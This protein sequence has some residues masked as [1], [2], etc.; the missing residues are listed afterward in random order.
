LASRSNPKASGPVSIEV[1]IARQ[2]MYIRK[3]GQLYRTIRVSTGS[4]KRYCTK[5]ECGVA[6]TPRGRFRIGHRISGW[7]TSRLGRLFSPLY[8]SGGFAIHGS[9]SVPGYPASH[10][11]VR[12]TMG[13]ARWLPSQVPNGTPVWIH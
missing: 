4:G 3:G 1:S 12:I 13:D 8:F 11:C 7:R 5:G 6:V 9:P 2:R 10:G